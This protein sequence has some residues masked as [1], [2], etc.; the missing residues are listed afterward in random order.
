MDQSGKWFVFACGF[1]SALGLAGFGL[2]AATGQSLSNQVHCS[3]RAALLGAASMTPMLAVLWLVAAAPWSWSREILEFLETHVGPIFSRWSILQLLLLSVVAGVGEEVL[4]R[5]AIQALLGVY[6]GPFA[7]LAV[8]SVL[9]GC[10]HAVTRSYAVLAAAIGAYLGL[11][12]LWSGNLLI[13]I[14][15]HA[16]YDFIALVYFLRIRTPSHHLL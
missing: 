14:I 1:E 4:F 12:W 10:V 7:G 16:L 3:G 6:L 15:A 8:A 13:A 11:L 5:G 9:F 2:A